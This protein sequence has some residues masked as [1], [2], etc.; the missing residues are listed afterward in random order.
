MNAV[1]EVF[2]CFE[3]AVHGQGVG[4]EPRLSNEISEI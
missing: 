4:F 1:G 2:G 3:F